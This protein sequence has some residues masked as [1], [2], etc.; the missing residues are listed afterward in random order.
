MNETFKRSRRW[1]LVLTLMCS[2]GLVACGSDDDEPEPQA[3]P[4]PTVRETAEGPVKGVEEVYGYSFKGIPYAAAPVGELRFA[5]PQSAPERDDTLDAGAFGND[6]P[7]S[8]GAVGE[9]AV[10]ED[11]L[12]LNIYTPDDSTEA[13]HPVMVW[14]HGGAFVS[15]SGGASY[16]PSR[17]VE[18]GVTVVTLNYRLGALGFM[19]S[20]ALSAEQG[21]SGNYGLLDQKAALEWVQQNISHFGGDPEQ[22]TIFG[23]SAG[24]HS[25]MSLLV[26]PQTEGLFHRAIVQSGSYSPDKLALDA[27]EAKGTDFMSAVGCSDVD[28]LQALSVETILSNQALVNEGFGPLP[29]FAPNAPILTQSIRSSLASSAFNK[30]PVLMGTNRDEYTLF[31]ALS[32]VPNLDAAPIPE[33][34]YEAEVQKSYGPTLAPMLVNLYPLSDYDVADPVRQATAAMA[35]DAGFACSALTMA[36]DLAKEVTTYVYEFADRDAPLNLLPARPANFELGAAHAFE[37]I[38]VL[39]TEEVMRQR[40]A[41]DAQVALSEQ[42]IDYWT[43]FAKNGTPNEAQWATFGHSGELLELNTPAN[44]PLAA[45]DFSSAHKCSFWTSF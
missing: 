23:E 27:A 10:N 31:T 28:C 22:V 34:D 33:T 40:G 41:T 16:N 13:T 18:E 20:P 35:T 36:T 3:V 26:S 43:S 42:M 12:F 37:I 32:L 9:A 39:N 44:Q 1:P 25:V 38:Y 15:G 19:A 29:I 8:G 7:Q 11:C 30:V 14:I 17:L 2:L 21:A 24:G 6:C 4:E 5:A 45:A